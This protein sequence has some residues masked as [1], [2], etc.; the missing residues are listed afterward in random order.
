MRQ[1]DGVNDERFAQQRP[2][3]R[4]VLGLVVDELDEPAFDAGKRREVGG[5]DKGLDFVGA[6]EMDPAIERVNFVF[7]GEKFIGG[8]NDDGVGFVLE[9]GLNGGGIVDVSP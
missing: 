4:G 7:A 9:C 2:D 3:K 5:I 8:G 1:F 6:Y